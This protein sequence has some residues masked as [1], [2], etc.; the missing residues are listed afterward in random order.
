MYTSGLQLFICRVQER[1]NLIK[2]EVATQYRYSSDGRMIMSIPEKY[3]GKNPR[4]LYSDANTPPI[5]LRPDWKARIQGSFQPCTS[6]TSDHAMILS[7]IGDQ[8]RY[9]R[10]LL[11]QIIET[12]HRSQRTG[13]GADN[14]GTCE[15]PIRSWSYRIQGTKKV[16][17]ARIIRACFVVSEVLSVLVESLSRAAQANRHFR[18]SS[19][20]RLQA[21]RYLPVCLSIAVFHL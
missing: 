6:S 7:I 14:S 16:I 18:W 5:V 17:R 2:P 1:C 12:E 21:E 19:T 20:L 11:V 9:Q 8:R 3:Y 4:H 10:R 15:K 13:R